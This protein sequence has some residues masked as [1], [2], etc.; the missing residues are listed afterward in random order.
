MILYPL[1]DNMMRI[2]ERRRWLL[3]PRRCRSFRKAVETQA[4]I[5]NARHRAQSRR[6]KP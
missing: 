1:Y 2:E 5:E 6:G 4:A 3:R